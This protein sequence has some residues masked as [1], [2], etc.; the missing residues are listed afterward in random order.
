MEY[1]NSLLSLGNQTAFSSEVAAKEAAWKGPTSLTEASAGSGLAVNTTNNDDAVV[2]EKR[3]IVCLKE[4]DYIGL[5]TSVKPL[6]DSK[7]PNELSLPETDLHLGLGLRLGPSEKIKNV[8]ESEKNVSFPLTPKE[9]MPKT[10][11]E[12]PMYTF[13]E[14]GHSVQKS[15]A[16]AGSMRPMTSENLKSATSAKEFQSPKV[17]THVQD[18]G[19]GTLR[20]GNTFYG[21]HSAALKNGTKRGYTEAMNEPARFNMATEMHPAVA[22]VAKNGDGDSK[23]LP[24]HPQGAF[25]PN[26]APQKPTLPAHWHG[27]LE[28]S[29]VHSFSSNKLT[30]TNAPQVEKPVSDRRPSAYQ[31]HKASEACVE[32]PATNE[33]PPSKGQVVGWPPIRSYRKH[34]LAKPTEMFVKVNM[35]GM[36]VGRKVDLNA[37]IS[38]EGLL[39]ALEEMFQPSNSGGQGAA[40]GRE[41]HPND[42]KQFKL[43]HGSDFFLTYEDQ[44]GD[45]MLVGDVPWSMFVN[46]VR[47]LRIT[48]GSEATGLAPRRHDKI[49]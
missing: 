5:S 25:M 44:D 8:E 47:R 24:K 11:M 7:S 32:E 4:H 29:S 3:N 17:S 38:Y 40:L 45:W 39:T 46:M 26:W 42:A 6:P 41:N 31:P 20:V 10:D 35:D 19:E 34:T 1:G 18:H 28:Q 13:A 15:W 36:T 23:A 12:H 37:H 14:V 16:N 49:K 2:E 21:G 33:P 27:G 22:V 43:L 30:P 9:G 48:R